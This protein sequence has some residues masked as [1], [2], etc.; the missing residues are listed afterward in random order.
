MLQKLKSVFYL[1]KCFCM[2]V[3]DLKNDFL[4]DHSKYIK[5]K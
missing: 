5:M 2:R 3:S 1:R 4:F